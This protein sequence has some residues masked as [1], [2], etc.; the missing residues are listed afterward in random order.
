MAGIAM[1]CRLEK[2]L[3]IA[4]ITVFGILPLIV[5]PVYNSKAPKAASGPPEKADVFIVSSPTEQLAA[6]ATA[7]V[8]KPVYTLIA[9]IVALVLW[10]KA[11][12]EL[13]AL[14]WAMLFFFFGENFCAANFLFTYSHDS[15]L[16]EYLHSL[17][18]VLSFGFAAFALLEGIDRYALHYSDTNKTCALAGFC[19]RCHKFEDVSCGLQSAFIFF[20][21][22]GHTYPA[23]FT[24][25]SYS[26]GLTSKNAKFPS[27]GFTVASAIY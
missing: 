27:S 18:M 11:D 25:I 2:L 8:V 13:K 5:Y 14:K 4:L 17:G 16:L 15:H 26:P 3:L 9:L 12:I 22:A 6:V 21:I 24:S 20:G 10:K 23:A 19:R 1:V 7:F